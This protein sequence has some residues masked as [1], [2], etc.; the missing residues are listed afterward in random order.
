[1]NKARLLAV[2]PMAAFALMALPTAAFAAPAITVAPASGVTDG[3]EVTITGTGYPASTALVVVECS[4]PADQAACDTANIGSAT[5]DASGAVTAKFKVKSG[6]I[7]N[8]SC[9]ST[10]YLAVANPADPT[11]AAVG[12]FSFGAAETTA[13]P[14]TTSA[15]APTAVAAGSGGGADRNGT[16]VAV[17]VLASLGGLAIA[18]G[19]VRFARR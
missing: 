14:T 17:I 8:G 6:A 2:A 12:K 19:A 11:V 3:Q 15:P 9:A 18:G 5:S 16:P 13:T 1:M 7:G 4:A 10:C